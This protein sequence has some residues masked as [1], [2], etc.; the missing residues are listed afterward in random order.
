MYADIQAL[1]QPLS[2]NTGGRITTDSKFKLVYPNNV[3]MALTAVNSFGI[4]FREFVK[5]SFPN[6]EYVVDPR[7][8]TAAGNVVQLIAMDYDGKDVGFCAFN[9]KMRDYTPV[10][11]SSSWTQKRAAGTWGAIIK[12]PLAISQMIGV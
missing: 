10:R 5:E 12:Y 4:T 6:V 1:F 2:A 11:A 3:A 7:Y 8:N 9:N